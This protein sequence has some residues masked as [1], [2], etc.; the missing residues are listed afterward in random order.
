[1]LALI[2]QDDYIRNNIPE[3]IELSRTTLV[4]L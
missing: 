3:D 4:P 2:T 1:L